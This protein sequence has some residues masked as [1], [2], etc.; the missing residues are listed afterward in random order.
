MN[1]FIP[2]LILP[3]NGIIRGQPVFIAIFGMKIEGL[4]EAFKKI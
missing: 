3:L 1:L 2:T 4:V